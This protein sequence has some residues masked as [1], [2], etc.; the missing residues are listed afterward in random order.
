MP[1]LKPDPC[2]I[3]FGHNF[4]RS[5]PIV[6]KSYTWQIFGSIQHSFRESRS[7]SITLGAKEVQ[8]H[9]MFNFIFTNVFYKCIKG[10][11]SSEGFSSP[12]RPMVLSVTNVLPAKMCSFDIIHDHS[13]YALARFETICIK[14]LI[15]QLTECQLR[16]WPG[17]PLINLSFN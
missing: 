11:K 2:E 5:Y 9:I 14:L 7:G 8:T 13:E 12:V 3:S 6:L 16:N 17:C 4:F 10:M 15:L 1:H